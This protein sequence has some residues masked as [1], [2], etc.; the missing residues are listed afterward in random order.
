MCNKIIPRSL[1]QT[2]IA[3]SILTKTHNSLLTRDRKSTISYIF[4]RIS[5]FSTFPSFKHASCFFQA[6]KCNRKGVTSVSKPSIKKALDV[7]Q[8]KDYTPIIS[9]FNQIPPSRPFGN[10]KISLCLHIH[11]RIYELS[12][13]PL[14]IVELLLLLKISMGF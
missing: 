14:D 9:S 8:N 7:Q 4:V 3:V 12:S 2:Q 1:T 5:Q 13:Q 10:H 6:K 11:H